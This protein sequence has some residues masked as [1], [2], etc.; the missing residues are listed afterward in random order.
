MFYDTEY[1]L[2]NNKFMKCV[3]EHIYTWIDDYMSGKVKTLPKKVIPHENPIIFC[4]E[5]FLLEKLQKHKNPSLYWNT[6]DAGPVADL[7]DVM[8]WYDIEFDEKTKSLMKPV[9]QELKNHWEVVELKNFLSWFKPK[10][11]MGWHTNCRKVKHKDYRL[12]FVW[13]DEDNKSFFR[14]RDSMGKIHTKWER[15][16]WNLNWFQLGN[17]ENP[18]WH[19]IYSNCNRFSIGFQVLNPINGVL[20]EIQKG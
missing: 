6:S 13:C 20:S 15:K 5:D 12:Y 3:D 11:Y 2:N 7:K 8:L 10:N 1:L 19:C 16:G 4:E 18:T 14:W 17:C 9:I